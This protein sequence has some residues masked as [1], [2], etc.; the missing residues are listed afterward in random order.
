LIETGI[1]MARF[2]QLNGVVF[3]VEIDLR[4]AD[5][6]LLAARLG[7]RLLEITVEA[8]HLLVERD[9][10]G[11]VEAVSSRNGAV[12]SWHFLTW[13]PLATDPWLGLADHQRYVFSHVK[14]MRLVKLGFSH[15]HTVYWILIS[16][17]LQRTT[18]YD[19][20]GIWFTFSIS[21]VMLHVYS[22]FSSC[23]YCTYF[24]VD[25]VYVS[26]VYF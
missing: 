3:E 17:A 11:K 10:G 23:I 25:L 1:F 20:L 13:K 18:K 6:V 5:T 4:V 7:H 24:T 8:E 22:W 14:M 15:L 19:N 26:T 2:D 16:T 9:P 12:R 21:L